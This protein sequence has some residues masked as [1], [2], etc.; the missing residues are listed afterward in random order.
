M[1]KSRSK[2]FGAERVIRKIR[3]C[4]GKSSIPWKFHG[5]QNLRQTWTILSFILPKARLS[6][7][8]LEKGAPLFHYCCFFNCTQ[9]SGKSDILIPW[10]FRLATKLDFLVLSVA[11][12]GVILVFLQKRTPITFRYQCLLGIKKV[13]FLDLF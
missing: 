10:K 2:F 8:F 3:K 5:K 11:L 4:G 1:P 6:Q 9:K 13:F 7:L 12:F